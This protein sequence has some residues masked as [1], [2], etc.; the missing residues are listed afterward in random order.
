MK[1]LL[2]DG[3]FL[4]ARGW[5][6]GMTHRVSVLS[7]TKCKNKKNKPFTKPAARKPRMPRLVPEM[8]QLGVKEGKR[9]SRKRGSIILYSGP[10]QV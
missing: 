5:A 2:K 4:C 3:L 6:S 9:G 10:T 8:M 1:E 7:R